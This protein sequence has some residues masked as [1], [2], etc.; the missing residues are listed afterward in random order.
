MRII[1]ILDERLQREKKHQTLNQ[2]VSSYEWIN[3]EA[4]AD[5]DRQGLQEFLEFHR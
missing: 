1:Q 5:P 4:S 3:Q 2:G